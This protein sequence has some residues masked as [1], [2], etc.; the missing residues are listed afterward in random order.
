MSDFNHNPRIEDLLLTRREMLGRMGAGFA[1]LSLAGFMASEGFTARAE[2]A[3]VS[4]NPF[5]PKSPHFPGK[6]KRVIFLFMN[7]GPSHVD[8]FDPKPI[9]TRLHRQPLPTPYLPTERKTRAAYRPPF[10]FKK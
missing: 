2:A 4:G 10:E 6:A 8:T 3:P 9:L 7:G 5:A 1:G